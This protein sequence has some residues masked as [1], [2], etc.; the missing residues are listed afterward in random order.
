MSRRKI[1]LLA[2]IGVTY[3][4]GYALWLTIGWGGPDV[5]M[6]VSDV[7]SLV[8][9][10]LAF[11]CI[12]LAVASTSGRQRMAWVALA[13]GLASWFVGDAIWAIYELGLEVEVPFPSLAD[14]GYLLYY[15]F[16]FIV[17]VML[18]T[19]NSGV[20]V[21]RLFLDGQLMAV[22]L[23]ALAWVSG[24]DDVVAAGGTDPLSFALLLFYPLADVA[25]FTMAALM[26]TRAGPGQ[27]LTISLLATGIAA[28]AIADSIF[29]YLDIHG[30]YLS[31]NVID[32]LWAGG[33]ALMAAAALVAAGARWHVVDPRD[34][35]DVAVWVPYV[36]LLVAVIPSVWYLFN[37]RHPYPLLAALLLSMATVLVRQMLFVTE[38]RRLLAKVTDQAL[39]DPLTSLANRVLFHDRLAHAVAI[40]A[41]DGRD[42]AVLSLDLDD[43]KLVNDSLGHSAGDAVLIEVAERLRRSVRTGDTVARLG[44]DEFAVLIEGGTEPAL[45]SAE[46]ILEVFDTEFVVDEQPVDVRPSAGL[47]ELKRTDTAGLTSGEL[48]NQAHVAM[49]SAQR[50]RMSGIARFTPDMKLLDTDEVG[51]T[52]G[53]DTQAA[54]LG[55]M[56]L[57]S[58]LRTAIRD[59]ALST[60]YQ[61]KYHMVTGRIIGVEALVRWP[62]PQLGKLVPDQFLPMARQNGL[63]G[64][65]TEVVLRR[66]ADDAVT[67][68][69]LGF[70]VPFAINVFPPSLSNLSLASTIAGIMADRHLPFENVT[71]EITEELLLSNPERVREVLI[72]LH[73]FGIHVAVDDFGSGYSALD[74]LRQ[75]PIDELKLDKQLIAPIVEDPRAAVIV[76]KV[77][78]LTRELGMLCVAEGVEDA[79]TADL[80]IS[81]GCDLGQGF[82]FSPPVT[83]DALPRMVSMQRPRIAQC[84]ELSK[85]T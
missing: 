54:R 37:G 78:E 28:L 40:H 33:L 45:T 4:L 39:R 17:L 43:F 64:A 7:G 81:Y 67:W 83:A 36:P 12:M 13:A 27:R 85:Q 51:L 30:I 38:N 24:L 50:T 73:D 41:R 76:R 6:V 53:S 52:C 31:G 60:E 19:G 57:L 16:A 70:D 15:V 65:L 47:A 77:V 29:V 26:L 79:A 5:L 25:L 82:Y 9:E 32:V 42:V 74:Y 84:D 20:T 46:R 56:R 2:W 21:A 18:P 62:H 69:S 44:G 3:L 71:V 34:V 75:L 59:D 68:K 80:L 66:A 35:T 58:E 63:M 10:A 1:P 48:F 23:F 11:V 22:S 61:P 8:V 49:Y 14:V 72:R 55:G